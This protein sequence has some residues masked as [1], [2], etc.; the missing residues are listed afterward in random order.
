MLVRVHADEL[1]FAREA[2][3]G[4]AGEDREPLPPLR[5]LPRRME[6]C[7]LRIGQELDDPSSAARRSESRVSP[8]SRA[9]SAARP[10]VGA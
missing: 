4:L 5:V 8:H 3:D 7:E 10:H 2:L 9:S 6:A 1:L